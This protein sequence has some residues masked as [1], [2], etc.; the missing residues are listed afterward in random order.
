[1][2]TLTLTRRQTW[3]ACT[4]IYKKFRLPVGQ[5]IAGCFNL[6]PHPHPH[7]NPNPN[8]NPNPNLCLYPTPNP[9]QAIA[10]S[11]NPDGSR[12]T[13]IAGCSKEE[14]ELQAPT[15]GVLTLLTMAIPTVVHCTA[16]HYPTLPYPT[17]RYTTLR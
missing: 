13:A 11:F 7:P 15:I 6:N 8:T 12:G 1:M 4:R 2:L 3:R 14:A 16:L 10:G 17:P 9:N 5:A